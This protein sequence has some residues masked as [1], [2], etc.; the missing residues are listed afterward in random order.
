MIEILFG[1]TLG[2][3]SV[4]T[5]KLWGYR[6]AIIALQRDVWERGGVVDEVTRPKP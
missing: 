3:L 1:F 2:W 4:L 6:S 5:Y